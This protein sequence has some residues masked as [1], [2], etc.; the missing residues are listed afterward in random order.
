M[1]NDT[2]GAVYAKSSG[3]E[4]NAIVTSGESLWQLNSFVAVVFCLYQVKKK[5]KSLSK[6]SLISNGNNVYFEAINFNLDENRNCEWTLCVIY[7]S[8]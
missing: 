2:T 5:Q 1:R 8:T 7:D 6:S 4:L 3:Y